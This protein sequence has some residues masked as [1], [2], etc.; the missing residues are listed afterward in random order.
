MKEAMLKSRLSIFS[1]LTG[2][3]GRSRSEI[4]VEERVAK[5]IGFTMR[6][7]PLHTMCDAVKVMG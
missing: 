5:V 3:S 7:S 1:I 2:R 4:C 6:V